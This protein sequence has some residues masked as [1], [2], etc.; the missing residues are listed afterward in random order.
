MKQ[1]QLYM[2][3]GTMHFVGSLMTKD[4]GNSL[5]LLT[6]FIFWSFTAI[7]SLKFEYKMARI[8]RTHERVKFH[9]IVELLES[10]RLNLENI[11]L[12]KSKKKK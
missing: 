4:I 7:F 6:M 12:T 11:R 8:E 5:L 1:S 9:L 10:I 3:L 2:I